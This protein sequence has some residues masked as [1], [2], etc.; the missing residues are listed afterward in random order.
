MRILNKKDIKVKNAQL[1]IAPLG[2]VDVPDSEWAGIYAASKPV[3]DAVARGYLRAE[4]LP[5][6]PVVPVLN[7]TVKS[8]NKNSKK[9]A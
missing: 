4:N 6:E 2:Y 7:S 1:E 5:E 9:G 3:R 8:V